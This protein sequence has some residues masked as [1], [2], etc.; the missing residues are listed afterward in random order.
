MLKVAV[1]ILLVIC[2]CGCVAPA[3]LSLY[4]RAERA[5]RIEALLTQGTLLLR[6]GD[7][8]SLVRAEAAFRLVQELDPQEPRGADGLGAVAWRRGDLWAAKMFFNQAISIDPSYDRPYAH[9]A[10]IA[11][12][13]GRTNDSYQLL[14]KAMELNPLNYRARNNFSALLANHAAGR[15]DLARSYD[16]I[17]KA[18]QLSPQKHPI[19]E[20]NLRRIHGALSNY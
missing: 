15:S 5:Q 8:E 20:E 14:Q 11:D 12:M 10:L 4:E 3:R 13:E 7:Q 19:I 2:C 1:I 6:Q 16:E 18:Q 17:I 9:L